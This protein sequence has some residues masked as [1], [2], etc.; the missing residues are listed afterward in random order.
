VPPRPEQDFS[1][2]SVSS[3]SPTSTRAAA[4][5]QRRID[6]IIGYGVLAEQTGLD[7]FGVGEHHT[8]QFAVSSP[9]VVFAAIAQRTRRITLT[10]TA[11]VLSV[12]DPMRVF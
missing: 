9:A 10:T 2:N 5:P 7:V 3:P 12:L 6:D 1:W 4:T 8:R 11:T